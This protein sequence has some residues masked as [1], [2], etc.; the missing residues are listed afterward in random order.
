MSAPPLLAQRMDHPSRHGARQHLIAGIEALHRVGCPAA[1][2]YLLQ[3]SKHCSLVRSV[4]FLQC[5]KHSSK[6]GFVLT[7]ALLT[8]ALLKAA[9]HCTSAARDSSVAILF[10]AFACTATVING[11]VTIVPP[12]CPSVSWRAI[13]LRRKPHSSCRSCSVCGIGRS[14]T[15][16]A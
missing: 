9:V 13:S 8:A 7:G 6:L 10:L 1:S 15:C 3:A 4:Y 12:T 11:V 5:E 14:A 16:S 2:V